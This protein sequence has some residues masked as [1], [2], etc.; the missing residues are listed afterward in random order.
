MS[1]KSLATDT[2]SIDYA[3]LLSELETLLGRL[4]SASD[5]NTVLY[6]SDTLNFEPCRI[7]NLYSFCNKKPF[8]TSEYVLK[9]AE[10][11]KVNNIFCE[12]NIQNVT[13]EISPLLKAVY[14]VFSIPERTPYPSEIAYIERWEKEWGM[15]N[16]LILHACKKTIKTIN[17]PSF[18]YTE[19]ILLSLKDKGI[20]TYTDYEQ[21]HNPAATHE[22]KRVNSF[23]NFNERHY[24]F[25]QLEKE[26]FGD[27][28]N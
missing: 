1:H 12:D 4:L 17:S 28:N 14:D 10:T 2:A 6:L 26:V 21:Q 24:D 18:A 9:V 7:K 27:T 11:W 8:F 13:V 23:R 22:P 25:E 15:D 3:V 5:V 16:M 19:Q 20:Q